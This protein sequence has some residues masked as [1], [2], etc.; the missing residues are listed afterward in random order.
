MTREECSD[1][2]SE[3]DQF[4]NMY[5]GASHE[6]KE[7]KAEVERLKSQSEFWQNEFQSGIAI[8]KQK[9][10]K[11]IDLQTE[12]ERLK[13]KINNYTYDPVQHPFPENILD[14][15]TAIEQ[16][17]KINETGIALR[18]NNLEEFK[19]WMKKH[20]HTLLLTD[21]REA[22]NKDYHLSIITGDGCYVTPSVQTSPPLEDK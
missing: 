22:I 11:I 10:A 4:K 19:E 9:D 13:K 5:A 14:R 15:L 6:I 16:W 21:I 1:Y 7:L 8:I 17:I 3:L 12:V 2:R 18:L 20:T